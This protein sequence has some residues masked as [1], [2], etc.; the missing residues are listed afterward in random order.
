MPPINGWV[1]SY[2]KGGTDVDEVRCVCG[3]VDSDLLDRHRVLELQEVSGRT[4]KP[5]R[6]GRLCK[7]KAEVIWHS[8]LTPVGDPAYCFS[9]NLG[10][11]LRVS[12]P[13]Q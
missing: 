11:G 7:T 5:S 2:R 4:S 10:I 8:C 1:A 6:S 3:L 12:I 9:A 13:G